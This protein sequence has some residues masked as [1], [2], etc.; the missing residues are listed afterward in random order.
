MIELVNFFLA[1]IVCRGG[2]NK[3]NLCWVGYQVGKLNS[4]PGPGRVYLVGL[5]QTPQYFQFCL[6]GYANW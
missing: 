2:T 5:G 6:R 4:G 3:E 1:V